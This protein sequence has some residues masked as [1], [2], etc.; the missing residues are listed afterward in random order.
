MLVQGVDG[1][2]VGICAG[3]FSQF[4]HVLS[5]CLATTQVF[6]Q[7]AGVGRC[8]REHPC[9][10]AI[11]GAPRLVAVQHKSLTDRAQD[12]AHAI[13]PAHK[14]ILAAH[15]PITFEVLIPRGFEAAKTANFD[16]F[17]IIFRALDDPAAAVK[18]AGCFTTGK[19]NA[20]VLSGALTIGA[21]PLDGHLGPVGTSGSRE[22]LAVGIDLYAT[23]DALVTKPAVAFT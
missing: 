23:G 14:N 16:L 20:A 5:R 4:Q 10:D 12:R 9:R 8:G 18:L 3:G 22:F 21:H 1:H 13:V 2:P 17:V 19:R 6:G 11:Q 15:Q 7:L